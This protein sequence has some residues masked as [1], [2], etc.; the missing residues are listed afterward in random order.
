MPEDEQPAVK[1]WRAVLEAGFRPRGYPNRDEQLKNPLNFFVNKYSL[2]SRAINKE[3]KNAR[4][5]D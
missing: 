3:D 2:S 4:F 1:R 5:I